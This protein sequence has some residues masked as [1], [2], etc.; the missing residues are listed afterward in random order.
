MPD[1]DRKTVAETRRGGPE[2]ASVA[3]AARAGPTG[4]QP[5]FAAFSTS[6]A[7]VFARFS[8]DMTSDIMTCIMAIWII[9]GISALVAP[10]AAPSAAFAIGPKDMVKLLSIKR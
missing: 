9:A 6:S 10:D 2:A 7:A 3:L 5:F 4:R 1:L 8:T